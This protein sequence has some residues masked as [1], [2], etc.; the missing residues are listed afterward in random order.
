MRKKYKKTIS[1]ATCSQAIVFARV[2]SKKQKDKGVSLDVQMEAITEYCKNKNLKILEEFTIDES[3]TKGE[4]AQYNEMLSFAQSCSG[5]VAIVVNYVDRLQR[6]YD[7]TYLLNKLRKEGKIEVHFLKEGLI[8]NKN[9]DSMELNFWHM[10]VLMAN[11]QVN[12]MIDKVRSSQ[13]HNRELGKIQGLAPL[14]Y[15]N[16]RDD[17][18]KANVI[19]DSVRAP[20]V[21]KLYEEYATGSHS[22]KTIWLLAK[23][24]G[25]YTRSKKRKGLFV[26]K[27][28]VYDV[29]TNPFYYGEMCINGEFM[30]HIY[31]PLITKSLYEKVQELF[32]EKGNRNRT[33]AEEYAK[34]PYIFRGFIHCKDCGCLIT[35]ETKT[36]KNGTKYIYLRCGHPC[37]ECHQGLVNENVILE[38][39]KEEVFDKITLPT[40]LQET[41]KKQLLQELNDTSRFNAIIKTNITNQLTELKVKEDKL[42]DFYL[43][44]KL[45]QST[46]DMKKA[47]IDKELKELEES[48]E[49]YKTID[50]EMKETINKVMSIACNISYIFEKASITRKSEL[51]R[52]LIADCKLNGSRLEYKLRAPFDKLVK[53]SN[54]KNWTS[55]AIN[56]LDEFEMVNV[57]TSLLNCEDL[58]EG[59]ICIG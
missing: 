21:K 42:L 24:L 17:D 39:L 40:T 51:L 59:T 55:I 3:S 30:P 14:G 29:L 41:L 34:T 19:V 7:D 27:N 5:K 25:L 2:S 46:Y 20:I 8:I 16:K 38:Q 13:Q 23:Q 48:A 50:S 49:R 12:N 47:L 28:T 33:N 10:H 22:L 15:L 35:P 6:S 1:H 18:N 26:S 44:E 11:S 36:K 9:S 32:V 43:E 4:R 58:N 54:Y 31:P 53:C 56:H 57:S 45:P 52:L 37:K